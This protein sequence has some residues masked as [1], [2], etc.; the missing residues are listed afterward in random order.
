MAEDTAITNEGTGAQM[1]C[2]ICGKPMQGNKNKMYCSP[3][4]NTKAYNQRKL[5]GL[6][7]NNEGGMT[8][9]TKDQSNQNQFPSFLT[10]GTIS[11]LEAFKLMQELGELK[12]EKK[13]LAN[14][15]KA[16]N[17]NVQKLEL[18]V[19]RRDERDAAGLQ[20]QGL[21]GIM[22]SVTAENLPDTIRAL[23]ELITPG[24]GNSQQL[25]LGGDSSTN[26][27]LQIIVDQ[28]KNK[29]ADEVGNFVA[30]VQ[31]YVANPQHLVTFITNLTEAKQAQQ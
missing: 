16:A 14:E 19:A 15:L 31:F 26:M 23:K 5:N 20:K 1:C 13:E 30:L 9:T 10:T 11:A 8:Q 3:S 4:C 12:A 7:S 2:G 22:G 18:E 29:P 28:L 24:A 6:S 21:N 17:A 27:L 25:Q